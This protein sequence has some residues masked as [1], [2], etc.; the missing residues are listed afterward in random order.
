VRRLLECVG[1]M[2]IGL[3]VLLAFFQT[4]DAYGA[5]VAPV[6][7]A[8][9]NLPVDKAARAK[10]P[11]APRRVVDALAYVNRFVNARMQPVTDQDHYGVAELWVMY[12]QDGKGDCEDYALTKLGLLGEANY[13]L[14]ANAKIVG[15]GVR[16]K[17]QQAVGHIILAIRLPG[18]AVAYLDNMYDEPMTR[19]ELVRAGYIFFDW[20]A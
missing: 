12:P 20:R 9:V 16:V 15:V 4:V 8:A 18:G 11:T 6:P 13:P 17:G 14:V 7:G 2:A 1:F 10:F 3:L 5:P 19:R